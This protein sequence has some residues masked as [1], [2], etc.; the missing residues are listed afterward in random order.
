MEVCLNADFLA[1]S[2]GELLT[3][4]AQNGANTTGTFAGMVTGPAT[5]TAI[6]RVTWLAGSGASAVSQ[7]FT[8]Q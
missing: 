7:P 4:S 1:G 2:T 8:I 3:A 6:V 5:A